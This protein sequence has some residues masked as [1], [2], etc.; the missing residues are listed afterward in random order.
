MITLD[1]KG[2]I[3]EISFKKE[4]RGVSYSKHKEGVHTSFLPAFQNVI[5]QP[6]KFLHTV[7]L[8]GKNK[9]HSLVKVLESYS[10]LPSSN[11]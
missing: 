8:N 2:A 6:H 4:G 10:P 7:Q 9:I 3:N 11:F 1:V 5:M